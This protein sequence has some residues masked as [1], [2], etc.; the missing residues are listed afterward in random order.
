MSTH[1]S[2]IIMSCPSKLH[3]SHDRFKKKKENILIFLIFFFYIFFMWFAILTPKHSIYHKDKC[4][5]TIK[6]FIKHY[7]TFRLFFLL[8]V[9]TP[10]LFNNSPSKL[11]HTYVFEESNFF[12]KKSTHFNSRH[13]PIFFFHE[14]EVKI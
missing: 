4:P 7:D 9:N 6:F 5:Q 2:I 3:Y 13:I 10:I 1:C 12:H 8:L 14:K 11:N